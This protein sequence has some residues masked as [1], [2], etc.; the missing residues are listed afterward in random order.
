M[1]CRHHYREC[2]GHFSS[3]LAFDRHRAGPFDG[4]RRCFYPD[5]AGL[6]ERTGTCAISD[7]QA[8]RVAVMVHEYGASAEA[9]RERFRPVEDRRSDQGRETAPPNAREAASA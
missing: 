3:L 7:P 4:E 1:T 6:I 5:D 8:P 2:G 9:A